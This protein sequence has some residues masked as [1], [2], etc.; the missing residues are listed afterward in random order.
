MDWRVACIIPLQ[1]GEN[2]PQGSGK[3]R[4]TSLLAEIG[5]MSVDALTDSVVE[6]SVMEKSEKYFFDKV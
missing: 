2:D 1:K 3:N 6:S 5:I 4:G